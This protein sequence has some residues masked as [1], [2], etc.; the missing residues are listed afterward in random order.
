MLF[1]GSSLSQ[2]DF[3]FFIPFE[4]GPLQVTSLILAGIGSPSWVD[5]RPHEMLTW[6][7]KGLGL[8]P[9]ESVLFGHLGEYNNNN[10]FRLGAGQPIG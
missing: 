9:L 2:V 5:P 3:V 6:E 8:A 7:W 1:M 10:N 4:R